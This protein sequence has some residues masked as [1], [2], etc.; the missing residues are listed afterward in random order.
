MDDFKNHVVCFISGLSNISN[1][2]EFEPKYFN[3]TLTSLLSRV[4]PESN[5]NLYQIL[6]KDALECLTNHHVK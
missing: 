3:F 4:V 5:K 6:R 1:S 2:H